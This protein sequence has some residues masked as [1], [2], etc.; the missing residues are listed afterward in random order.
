MALPVLL[1]HWLP[2]PDQFAAAYIKG[3]HHAAGDI[4]PLIIRH[5]GADNR[6]ISL[7]IRRRG[8]VVLPG[9][10]PSDFFFQ[11]NATLVAKVGTGLAVLGIECNQLGVAGAVDN[12]RSAGFVTL[13]LRGL[14]Q[15]H[16]AAN[17]WVDTAFFVF[18]LGI[19]LPQFA[20]A[21]GI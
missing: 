9:L 14:P 18:Y 6:Y 1:A 10:G 21:F 2:S 12:S 7:N 19:K 16:A 13:S 17:R 5:Q 11:G 3:A 20:T 8:W 15:G 4:N